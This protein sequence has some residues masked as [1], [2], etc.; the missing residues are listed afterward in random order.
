[1]EFPRRSRRRW[2]R[3]QDRNPASPQSTSSRHPY[4]LGNVMFLSTLLLWA[5]LLPSAL[6]QEDTSDNSTMIPNDPY[7]S[8]FNFTLQFSTSNNACAA[9]LIDY[10]LEASTIAQLKAQ[11]QSYTQSYTE[12]APS[13]DLSEVD[14]IATIPVG[15][16]PR[17][18]ATLDGFTPYN[19]SYQM[20]F[21]TQEGK[22]ANVTNYPYF[23]YQ[24]FN[25]HLP[26]FEPVFAGVF[27]TACN[28]SDDF[29][30]NTTSWFQLQGLVEP[31]PELSNSTSWRR[32][33]LAFEVEGD[34]DVANL[35]F[36]LR[37]AF[38]FYMQNTTQYMAPDFVASA[39]DLAYVSTR[40]LIR[41]AEAADEGPMSERIQEYLERQYELQA[42]NAAAIAAAAS[43]TTE[44]PTASPVSSRLRRELEDVV[45]DDLFD[46][47]RELEDGLTDDLMGIDIMG[48]TTYIWMYHMNYSSST[49]N[50]TLYPDHYEDMMNSP[51]YRDNLTAQM[52]IWLEL[53][54]DQ[55]LAVKGVF[56]LDQEPRSLLGDDWTAFPTPPPSMFDTAPTVYSTAAPTV[57]S[58]TPAP[59]L[60]VNSTAV[61]TYELT[62]Q[63]IGNYST[64]NSENEEVFF[65]DEQFCELMKNMTPQIANRLDNDTDL[66]YTYCDDV[67][68][69]KLDR[70]RPGRATVP[71]KPSINGTL[72]PI[73]S[74]VIVFNDTNDT[75]LLMTAP[76]T[77]LATELPRWSWRYSF[78]M[79]YESLYVNVTLYPDYFLD[80]VLYDPETKAELEEEM[81][82]M[83]D[84]PEDANLTI[85]DVVIPEDILVPTIA[86]TI[87]TSVLPTSNTSVPTISSAP[88]EA[89]TIIP[90]GVDALETV[91]PTMVSATNQSNINGNDD[92]PTGMLIFVAIVVSI[93]AAL[94]L[95]GF[96]W[97]IMK[98]VE[99]QKAQEQAR[100]R[101]QG[102]DEAAKVSAQEGSTIQKKVSTAASHG[103]S[104]SMDSN[105][106]PDQSP[107]T[108]TYGSDVDVD[109]SSTTTVVPPPDAAA[110]AAAAGAAAGAA[111]AAEATKRKSSSK[112]SKAN[113]QERSSLLSDIEEDIYSQES[114]SFK[115][116]QTT[117]SKSGADPFED[118][119]DRYKDKNLEQMRNNVEDNVNGLDDMMSH[120]MT[121][122]L[123]MDTISQKMPTLWNGATDSI[124]IEA[125]ALWEVTD[126]MKRH[127]GAA[128][129][130][131]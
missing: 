45:T 101:Q 112:S 30:T 88:S 72:P 61:N 28:I 2:R 10:Q 27:H 24:F 49:I 92:V 86:P 106:R 6:S 54:E 66:I 43:T 105:A 3:C 63:V 87:H 9:P 58:P 111:A 80:L 91:A 97:F 122:A 126:W 18:V 48:N 130:E 19:L 59:S 64:L 60:E 8:T 95:A 76:P 73:E 12:Y 131:K 20:T 124:Q 41:G 121:N 74:V 125:N 93:L 1:M 107:T 52:K 90:I 7:F 39:E 69:T 32:F 11:L 55:Y 114:D 15:T 37:N 26:E 100:R 83:K 65:T 104:P 103:S 46:I 99:K 127:D 44:Q 16:A 57:F 118:E 25:S 120:A 102:T 38:R 35:N 70:P 13:S 51:G 128:T 67:K 42:A 22:T 53:P 4:G 110:G 108:P 79:K 78:D 123:M 33:V 5:S 85:T 96:F 75:T 21:E 71:P 109:I 62:F 68:A 82:I 113:F 115:S 129:D 119:L 47:Y 116:R 23:H 81:S 31:L 40:S 98:R 14:T 17:I 89:P 56:P 29:A 77:T 34:P 117:P 50:V 84:L 36:D 94:L